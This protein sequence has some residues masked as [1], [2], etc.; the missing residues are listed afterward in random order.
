MG[1][2]EEVLKNEQGRVAALQGE[3]VKAKERAK[4]EIAAARA[5]AAQAHDAAANAKAKVQKLATQ[6]ERLNADLAAAMKAN[7]ELQKQ[8]ANNKKDG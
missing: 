6:V 8:L 5:K 2:L 4:K 3:L 1:T 7:G